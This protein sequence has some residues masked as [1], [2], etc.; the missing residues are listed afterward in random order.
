[1][2]S[3]LGSILVNGLPER[4]GLVAHR[5][6]KPIGRFEGEAQVPYQ[7]LDAGEVAQ[8]SG[9]GHAEGEL[10]LDDLSFRAPDRAAPGLSSSTR[11]DLAI[12]K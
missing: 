9:V 4:K 1:M 11:S 7:F 8:A 5:R 10:Q 3:R 12:V 2:Q 6:V